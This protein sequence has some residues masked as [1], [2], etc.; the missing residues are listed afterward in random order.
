MDNSF[1]AGFGA[2]AGI[3]TFVVIIMSLWLFIAPLIMTIQLAGINRKL[4]ALVDRGALP[5]QAPRV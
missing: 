1:G 4:K 2:V 5:P 3:L